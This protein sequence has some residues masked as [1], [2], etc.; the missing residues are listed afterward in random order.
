M[1]TFSDLIHFPKTRVLKTNSFSQESRLTYSSWLTKPYSAKFDKEES[2]VPVCE[3]RVP[4]FENLAIPTLQNETS[5][6]AGIGLPSKNSLEDL[7]VPRNLP[8]P[9][10][11]GKTVDHGDGVRREL[12]RDDV[13]VIEDIHELRLER[14]EQPST[15]VVEAHCHLPFRRDRETRPL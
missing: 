3:P 11:L 2:L 15:Q 4:H 1:Y 10:L 14:K 7:D 12:H 5:M 8:T 13:E 9:Q 6:Q